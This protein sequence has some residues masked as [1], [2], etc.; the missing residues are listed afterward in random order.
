[1]EV[2]NRVE[3]G[4]RRT[5]SDTTA[6]SRIFQQIKK[7]VILVTLI[8]FVVL[9]IFICYHVHLSSPTGF[10]HVNVQKFSC[11]DTIG[12]G[13]VR[14]NVCHHLINILKQ[15]HNI[16]LTIDEFESVANLLR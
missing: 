11:K 4:L 9:E 10:G 1:M 6:S 15:T 7:G 8:I 12:V 13:D 3:A 16:S 5:S 14:M 2:L